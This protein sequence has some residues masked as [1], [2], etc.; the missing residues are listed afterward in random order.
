[1]NETSLQRHLRAD[2]IRSKREDGQPISE[3]EAKLIDIQTDRDVAYA[4][5]LAGYSSGITV[6][7]GNRILVTD[8]AKLI[9]PAEGDRPCLAALLENL[10]RDSEYDQRP[11]VLGWLKVAVE[12][13]RSGRHRPGQ[14][15]AIAG[16]RGCGKSLFQNLTTIILGGRVAKPYRYMSGG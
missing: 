5:P 4:G 11:S 7:S 13:L 8:S 10:F 12:C 9:A 3:L 2:G 15:L 16:E 1:V 6:M 14:A